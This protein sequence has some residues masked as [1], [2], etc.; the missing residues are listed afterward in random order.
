MSE[1]EAAVQAMTEQTEACNRLVEA[2]HAMKNAATTFKAERDAA[3]ALLREAMSM[4][5]H[6]HTNDLRS[7]ITKELGQ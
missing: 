6:L 5:V 3:R 7:R 4:P 1:I 2:L